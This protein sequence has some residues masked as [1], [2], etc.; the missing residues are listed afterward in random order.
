MMKLDNSKRMEALK[1]ML[2]DEKKKNKKSSKSKSSSNS[3]GGSSFS[4]PPSSCGSVTSNASSSVPSS[5]LKLGTRQGSSRSLLL[6]GEGPIPD[7][8]TIIMNPKHSLKLQQSWEDIR[9]TVPD[10][11]MRVGEEFLLAMWAI[12]A[13]LRQTMGISSFSSPAFAKL[14]QRVTAHVEY[15]VHMSGPST[16]QELFVLDINDELR[17]DHVT[18]QLLADAIPTAMPRILG[19]DQYVGELADVWGYTFAKHILR[20]IE[21]DS[22]S[23]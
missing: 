20:M 18:G 4:P 14:C 16:S 15:F 6:L 17:Q 2:K 12:D 10:Y 9:R 8:M 13:T 21:D 3:R 19:P 11:Q 22:D 1:G 7:T 23:H 5:P